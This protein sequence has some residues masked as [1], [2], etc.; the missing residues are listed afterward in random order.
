[1]KKKQILFIETYATVTIY[2]MARLLRKK[3]YETILLRLLKPNDSDI[4]FYNNAYDKIIYF[5]L[6]KQENFQNLKKISSSLIKIYNLKPYVIF[7]RS[8][9][10]KMIF[11]FRLFFRKIPFIYYPYDIR[12]HYTLR[13]F[14]KKE[15]GFSKIEMFSE[16]YNF[17]HSQ[18]IIHKG[19]PEE[20]DEIHER[21]GKTKL[22][23][24]ILTFHSYCSDEFIIPLNK[25]KLSKKDGKIHL[26]YVGSGNPQRK[27]Y[28]EYLEFSKPLI[29]QEIHM[30]FYMASNTLINKKIVNEFLKDNKKTKNINYFHIHNQLDPKKIIKEIS[31]YDFGLSLTDPLLTTGYSKY[32]LEPR[33]QLGNKFMSYLEAGIP[34]F[35][36]KRFT[37]MN[38]LMKKYNLEIIYP[39][40]NKIKQFIKNLNY[41]ELEK[42]I[43]KARKDFNM[44]KHFPELEEFIKKVAQ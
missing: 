24:N 28:E 18:G 9:P 13:R 30:H 44:E 17:E 25:K 7:G 23:K 43:E 38:K 26:V 31:K 3:G 19:A 21:I 6:I 27:E 12:F 42:N 33:Y 29:N 40:L 11:L 32:D 22:P 37:F 8:N 20:L 39:E 4:N 14:A 5:N 1:M 35:S 36:G 2:K 34:F 10:N 16:K 41:K 15:R